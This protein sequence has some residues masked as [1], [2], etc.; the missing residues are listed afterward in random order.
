MAGSDA[1]NEIAREVSYWLRTKGGAAR[2]IT[3]AGLLLGRAPSSDVVLQGATAS[4]RQA[5]V[6]L[7]DEGPDV[8]VMGRG[9]VLVNGD[10]VP[11]SHKLDARS[12]LVVAGSEF[13]V[14]EEVRETEVEP[15]LW[16]LQA[17]GGELFS[18]SK[19]RFQVGDD[20]DL[21]IEALAPNVLAFVAEDGRLSARAKTQCGWTAR[22]SPRGGKPL[23]APTPRSTSAVRRFAWWRAATCSAA[24]RSL[25]SRRAPRRR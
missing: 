20:D 22:R 5:L 16:V 21:R 11:A 1:P 2:R 23:C 15:P 12:Q 10:R 9:E 8:A 4:R 6:Y 19:S 13:G 18:F 24:R 17:P 7:G 14:F 25:W 3:P